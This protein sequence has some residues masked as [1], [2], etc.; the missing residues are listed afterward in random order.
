MRERDDSKTRLFFLTVMHKHRFWGLWADTSTLTFCESTPFVSIFWI[1]V[2]SLAGSTLLFFVVTI[3]AET[4]PFFMNTSLYAWNESTLWVDFQKEQL[5]CYYG[6]FS[7][8]YF[9]YK[10]CNHM[11]NR[12]EECSPAPSPNTKSLHNKLCTETTLHW[13]PGSFTAICI[14]LKKQLVQMLIALITNM[15]MLRKWAFFYLMNSQRSG[16]C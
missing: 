13:S 2:H 14:A 5:S 9:E 4:R 8:N 16:C 3:S 15:L 11:G 12:V 10:L 7:P 6:D 1:S